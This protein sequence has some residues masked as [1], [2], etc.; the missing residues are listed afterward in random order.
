MDK[1]RQKELKEQYKE[2]KAYLGVVQITNQVNGKIYIVAVRNV[3]N[4]WFRLRMQLDMGSHANLDMQADWKNYSEDAF[5]YEVLEEKEQNA[6]MDLKWETKVLEK[7]WL[8]LLEPY[9]DKGY[10]KPPK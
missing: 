3:K 5:I 8:G 7:K 9:G 10:N 6:Q 2:T 1:Q 4:I